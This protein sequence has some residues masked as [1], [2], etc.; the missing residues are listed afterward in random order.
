MASREFLCFNSL[1]P[2]L[3][4]KSNLNF[5]QYSIYQI[6]PYLFILFYLLTEHPTFLLLQFLYTTP[7]LG[8]KKYQRLTK[9]FISDL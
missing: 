3:F 9:D 7:Q 6:N 4:K 1:C 2:F 5:S 8:N